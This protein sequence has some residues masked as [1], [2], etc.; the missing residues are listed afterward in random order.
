LFTDL[1]MMFS[2]P[3]RLLMLILWLAPI[4]AHAQPV[5]PRTPGACELPELGR[6]VGTLQSRVGDIGEMFGMSIHA[7]GDLNGDSLADWLVLHRRVDTPGLANV[8]EEL[9]LYYGVRGGLPSIDDSLRIGPAEIGSRTR[10]IAAGDF[11]HDGHRDL[12]LSLELFG[13]T[14]GGPIGYDRYRIAVFWGNSQGIFTLADT[15]QLGNPSPIWLGISGGSTG[16]VDVDGTDDLLLRAG[17]TL[18][19]GAVVY[20]PF[21]HIFRGR[22]GGRWGRGPD[23]R[24]S[25]WRW[26]NPPKGKDLIIVDHDGDGALDIAMWY[27]QDATLSSV[28]VLYG[29]RGTLPDTSDLETIA[30]L[31]ANGRAFAFLDLTGD[32]VP[33]LVMAAGSQE[34]LKVFVGFR[35]Q[36]LIEQYGS[37]YDAP[38][39]DEPRW[40]GR[41][42]AEIWMP[43]KLD[44]GWAWSGF[45]SRFSLGDIGLDGVGDVCAYSDP[46]LICYN[47]G[48]IL[49]SLIDAFVYVPRIG[50]RYVT[51]LGNVDGSG[52][53]T[54]AVSYQDLL[55]GSGRWGPG[56]IRYVKA[57]RCVPRSGT[58]RLLPHGTDKP[59][60]IGP[61]SG[62]TL[63]LSVVPNPASDRALLRW[64]HS[65]A[66]TTVVTTDTRGAEMKRW[67]MPASAVALTLELG[68]WPR[69]AYR[70][71]VSTSDGSSAIPLMLR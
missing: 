60:R 29:T 33:E 63:A 5:D 58:T 52:D 37:G 40:W 21:V 41:P 32:R 42:W 6:M 11:D 13:D 54:I 46:W 23:S 62:P 45:D 28:S 49:D 64:P 27:D 12:V 65:S 51:N 7:V 53:N 43:L 68:D 34:K 9:L 56:G 18:V 36:R 61:G 25:T 44:S 66:T 4:G 10:F 31:Y 15:T 57:S 71:T 30:P 38:R 67:R 19:N 3:I 48:R 24:E 1:P 17:H 26:W 39:P 14:S 20:T 22:R 59:S 69:G 70:I 2:N 47:G 55:S 50:I 8:A 35:G 16:D